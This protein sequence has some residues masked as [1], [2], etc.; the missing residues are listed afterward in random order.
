M[1]RGLQSIL[2]DR[3]VSAKWRFIF[4]KGEFADKS[5]HKKSR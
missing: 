2:E 1:V 3:H 4:K 5:A